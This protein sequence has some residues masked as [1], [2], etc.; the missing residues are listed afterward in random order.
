MAKKTDANV[1]VNLLVLQEF[2][3]AEQS[4]N[5][6]REKW[7]ELRNKIRAANKAAPDEVLISRV[8]KDLNDFIES[9]GLSKRSKK[10][11]ESAIGLDEFKI[12]NSND[13]ADI[14]DEVKE[15][16]LEGYTSVPWNVVEIWVEMD[17]FVREDECQNELVEILS[18]QDFRRLMSYLEQR[19]DPVAAVAASKG[20]EKFPAAEQGRTW[21]VG[22]VKGHEVRFRRYGDA[23]GLRGLGA[24]EPREA[25]GLTTAE[26]VQWA[27]ENLPKPI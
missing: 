18:E 26:L 13:L 27:A 10:D 11:V 3:S 22:V 14:P 12:T 1:N 5:A 17:K 16:A 20:R 2:D 19:A 6:A 9:L 7:N 4:Y 24:V 25:T 21:T 8:K 23:W 15:R